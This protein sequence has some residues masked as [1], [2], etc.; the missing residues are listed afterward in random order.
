MAEGA[1]VRPSAGA[2]AYVPDLARMHASA[3]YAAIA[4]GS[5]AHE[6]ATARAQQA[7]TT[8]RAHFYET[9]VFSGP[10]KLSRDAPG[11]ILGPSSLI[12][13]AWAIFSYSWYLDI[14]DLPSADLFTSSTWHS[15]GLTIGNGPK[16]THT[17]AS[18]AD[19][20]QKWD[21]RSAVRVQLE[22]HDASILYIPSSYVGP[23]LRRASLGLEDPEKVVELLVGKEKTVLGLQFQLVSKDA[24]DRKNR[25]I[26]ELERE[27][28][29][30]RQALVGAGLLLVGAFALP[31][32]GSV[33]GFSLVATP[34][35][36][37]L[38]AST[39]P[40]ILRGVKVARGVLQSLGPDGVEQVLGLVGVELPEPGTPA[41][42]ATDLL[43]SAL[44]SDNDMSAVGFEALGN[45]VNLFLPEAKGATTG[46]TLNAELLAQGLAKFDVKQAGVAESFPA[47]VDLALQALDEGRNAASEWKHDRSY[48][49]ALR[50][51]A[52]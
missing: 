16:L 38:L 3:S 32:F 7:G 9:D 49:N 43:I 48:V 36:G 40:T 24:I 2:N 33:P 37:S 13:D 47:Y 30:M 34:K 6:V 46:T 35:A 31:L 19:L 41:R 45:A 29:F 1:A 42:A 44:A 21:G 28:A 14:A 17:K 10:E 23:E 12:E 4:E 51:M 22:N 39:L 50:G 8:V 27:N 20:R 26:S 52:G 15:G 25:R 18:K 11:T 5:I